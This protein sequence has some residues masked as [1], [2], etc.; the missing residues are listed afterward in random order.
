[1]ETGIIEG[2]VA[3]ILLSKAHF[4]FQQ[5]MTIY[6]S[7]NLHSL[8]CEYDGTFCKDF[9]TGS[10][11]FFLMSYTTV[12]EKERCFDPYGLFLLWIDEI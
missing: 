9:K 4:D 7:W 3:W 5:K 1:M 11:L 10:S 8:K 2:A 6:F 12:L